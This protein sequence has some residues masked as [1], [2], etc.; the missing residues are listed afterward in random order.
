MTVLARRSAQLVATQGRRSLSSVPKMH[1]AAGNWAA[2]SSKRPIDEDDT[3]V[4]RRR[5]FAFCLR[6]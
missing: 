6:F 2:L 1:K 5:C 4:R 3:H